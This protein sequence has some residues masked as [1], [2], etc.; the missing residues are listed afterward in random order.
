M[1]LAVRINN[2]MTENSLGSG[3]PVTSPW[4]T[5]PSGWA[6]CDVSL[7]PAVLA[8][9]I[10]ANCVRSG[11]WRSWCLSLFGSTTFMLVTSDNPVNNEQILSQ[12]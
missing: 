10:F 11:R 4:D 7:R 5:K 9:I 3:M 1:M 12:P 2:M 8:V 6:S